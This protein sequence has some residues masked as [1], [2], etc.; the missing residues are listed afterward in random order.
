M[1]PLCRAGVVR[2]LAIV[3]LVLLAMTAKERCPTYDYEVAH[4][5]SRA[6]NRQGFTIVVVVL[7]LTRII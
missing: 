5:Y 3:K 7:T 1:A 4:M 2:L 6:V